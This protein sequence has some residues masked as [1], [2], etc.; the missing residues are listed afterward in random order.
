[1]TGRPRR[2]GACASLAVVLLLGLF[3]PAEGAVLRGTVVDSSGAALA[4]AMVHVEYSGPAVGPA[5][6]C[7]RDGAFLLAVDREGTLVARCFGFET[8]RRPFVLADTAGV[9]RIEM[10]PRTYRLPGIEVQGLRRPTRSNEAA[11]PIERVEGRSL[12]SM[13]FATP[14]LADR[15]IETP[16]VTTVGRDEYSAAPAVRGLARFRTVIVLDGAR[17]NSDREIGPTA[18]FVDPATMEAVEIIRGPGSVLYGSD[19]I[20]GVVHVTSRSGAAAA[21]PAWIESGFSTVNRGVRTAAG[22]AWRAGPVQFGATAAY[23]HAGDYAL[24]GSAFPWSSS[25]LLARNSGFERRTL[26]ARAAWNGF[27]ASSFYS[28]GSDIGRPGRE[29]ESFTV[30]FDKNLVH[31]L[32]WNR[33]SGT[34]LEL[35]G[36]LHPTQWQAIVEEQRNG[37]TR[38]QI[39]DYESLDWSVLA[40]ASPRVHS[41]S[42]VVGAQAD[43]RSGV[44]IVRRVEER[45]S[46]GTVF[47]TSFDPW[48]GHASAGQ[49]G[50]FAHATLAG[51]RTKWVVGGRVDQ[52]WRRGPGRKGGNLVPT[53]QV[54]L[55]RDALGGMTVSA[56]LATA[57]REPTISELFFSGKRPAG[58]IEGNPALRPERSLQADVA[59]SASR[60]PLGLKLSAFAMHLRDWILLEQRGGS[61]DTLTYANSSRASL[62]GGSLEVKRHSLWPG[63]GGRM[64][65]D[66]IRGFDRSGRPLADLHGPRARIEMTATRGQVSGNVGWRGALAHRRVA[67]GEIPAAGYSLLEA[68]ARLRLGTMTLSAAVENLLDQEVYERN[69][70]V[71]Y[72]SPGRS[73]HLSVRFEP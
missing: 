32:S 71:S 17:I 12:E 36:T 31:S 18:G 3:A 57:F 37:G 23:A 39:R 21:G 46:A 22:G 68:G 66:W 11:V 8:W 55:V 10:T 34:P 16:E 48:V 4:E 28:L 51:T 56:N 33:R 38:T 24:P 67:E 49:A 1:M 13:Q 72:P 43:V 6:T 29:A 7:D 40:T 53:G 70:P 61:P 30:A 45:D 73:F 14:V 54:G 60:G 41:A 69:D 15:L 58:Y 20:G 50:A 44:R 62:F 27:E 25:A 35:R 2:V 9:Q 42:L 19:A 64:F 47:A 5:R 26:R 65:V 52:T 59:A 63:I